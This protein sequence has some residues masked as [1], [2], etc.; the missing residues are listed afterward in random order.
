MAVKHLSDLNPDGTVL[1]QTAADKVSFHGATPSAQG[2]HIANAT[3]AATA[4]S[5]LNLVIAALEAKG[6]LATS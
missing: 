4:I 5:Q 1:G 2:V 6:L 3:D